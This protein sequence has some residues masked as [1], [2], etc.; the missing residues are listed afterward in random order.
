[1]EMVDVP[2][3]SVDGHGMRLGES[4]V[5]RSGSELPD[6]GLPD[7]GLPDGGLPDGGLPDGGA[8]G[9]AAPRGDT[10]GG[11]AARGIISPRTPRAGNSGSGGAGRA[12]A[13]GRPRS[14]ADRRA[15]LPE[16]LAA[17][18]DAFERHLRLE[19]DLSAHSVRA[20]VTDVVGL[21]DH[22]SG[23]GHDQLTALDPAVLRSWLGRLYT[24]GAAR[25]TLARRTAA[26]RAFATFARRQ[27]W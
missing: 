24:D 27:G 9:R 4:A 26:A 1:D 5:K 20:Y 8:S 17:A 2:V 15:A 18:L 10:K 11:L 16:R 23:L 12:G 21:L 22:L 19:R 6:G 14:T 25:S 13:S 3:P 7:G